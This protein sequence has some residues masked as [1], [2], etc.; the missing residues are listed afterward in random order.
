VT[1]QLKD[2]GGRVKDEGKASTALT[3]SSVNPKSAFRI[4]VAVDLTC[5]K[6]VE[7][8]TDEPLKHTSSG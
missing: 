2:E 6:V 3:S 8:L 4:R 5:F 1:R 7:A